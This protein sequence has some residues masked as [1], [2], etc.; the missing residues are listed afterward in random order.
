MYDSYIEESTEYHDK[1]LNDFNT[2]YDNADN[3]D[4]IA[5][6]NIHK[7]EKINPNKK[8]KSESNDIKS[9]KYSSTC[10]KF[11]CK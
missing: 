4:I 6:S 7:K 11:Y 5:T 3:D 10:G 2:K 8:I 1:Q 9:E